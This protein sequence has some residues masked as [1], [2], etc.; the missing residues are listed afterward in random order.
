MC[1]AH[2]TLFKSL[3]FCLYKVTAFFF[4]LFFLK[5]CISF[6]LREYAYVDCS[7]RKTSTSPTHPPPTKFNSLE[8]LCN[9][10]TYNVCGSQKFGW[11]FYILV[12]GSHPAALGVSPGSTLRNRSWRAPGTLWDAGIRTTILLHTRQ[13]SH[14]YAISP[15]PEVP[16]Q[17]FIF[18]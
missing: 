1:R 2:K 13:M 8:A 16:Y 9:I 3:D 17:S 15:A 10:G 14:L 11:F 12:F 6:I 5:Y 4:Y 18:L 7:Q